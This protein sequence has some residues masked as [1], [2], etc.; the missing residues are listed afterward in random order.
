MEA[1]NNPI[2]VTRDGAVLTVTLNRAEKKNAFTQQ[3]YQA[4]ADAFTSVSKDESIKVVVFRGAG[5]C[6]S[7]GNDLQDFLSHQHAPEPFKH[8]LAFMR[9]LLHCPVPVVAEVQ[10]VAIG[11]GTTLLQHCDF[12]YAQ[13]D[14]KFAVPF[15]QLGLCPEYAASQRLIDIVGLRK[16]TE[17]LLLA[18]PF[19]AHEAL[20]AGLL[21]QLFDDA[22]ELTAQVNKTVARLVSLPRDAMVT[23]K[24]LIAAPD[25][26][27]VIERE[28]SEFGRLLAAEAAQEAMEAFVERRPVN[29]ERYQ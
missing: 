17:W 1:T 6:F 21:N 7:A 27:D 24:R 2:V 9:A 25:T 14:S 23:S 15:T 26:V 5:G 11:I 8:T 19:T 20:Q 4:C 18:E 28:I 13:S 16:A 29:A 12:V 22:T 10:G 3:M